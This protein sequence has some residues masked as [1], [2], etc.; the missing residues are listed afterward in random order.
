MLASR[1]GGAPPPIATMDEARREIGRC[2]RL[3]ARHV[4]LDDADYPPLL[5]AVSVLALVASVAL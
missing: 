3:G 2:A 5:A 1:G 4:F